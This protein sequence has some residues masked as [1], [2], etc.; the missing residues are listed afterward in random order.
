MLGIPVALPGATIA[1]W[2]GC[3]RGAEKIAVRR[4]NRG[5]RRVR[6]HA[7]GT[8]CMPGTAGHLA[9]GVAAH[10]PLLAA[11]KLGVPP[12]GDRARSLVE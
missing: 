8:E 3:G 4:K 6:S 7:Y 9:T 12:A 2:A 10:V 11:C 1:A 5:L